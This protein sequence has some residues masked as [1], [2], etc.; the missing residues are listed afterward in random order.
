MNT[1]MKDAAAAFIDELISLYVVGTIKEGGKVFTNAP[2]FVFENPRKPGQWRVL[3]D[4]L[5]SEQNSFIAQD[6]V[7]L[8]R[9]NHILDLMYIGGFSAVI[10]LSKLFYIF[11]THYDDRPYLGL[12]HPIT[13][14]LYCYYGQPMGVGNSPA[15]AGGFGLAFVPLLREHFDIF[16]EKSRSNCLWT[17]FTYKGFNPTLG[18]GY[19]LVGRDGGA[20]LIWV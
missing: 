13:K 17:S 14:I 12:L 18:Y 5:K 7:F 8:P 20:V 16:Q 6:P 9:V 4:M 3:A 19:V 1:A 10:N 15:I 11:P 2:I